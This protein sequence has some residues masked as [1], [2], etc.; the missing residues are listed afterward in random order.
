MITNINSH[1]SYKLHPE[2]WNDQPARRKD[3]LK[4]IPLYLKP[5]L[6]S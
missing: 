6:V 1:P 2:H 3:T 5:K 4:P